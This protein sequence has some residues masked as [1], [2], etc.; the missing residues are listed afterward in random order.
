MCQIESIEGNAEL[1]EYDYEA[2][3]TRRATSRPIDPSG[4]GGP[5]RDGGADPGECRARGRAWRVD[6]GAGWSVELEG[7]A[8][9]E[10]AAG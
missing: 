5:G 1:N 9:R 2:R 10:L 6:S 8:T 7:S 3:E 4:P